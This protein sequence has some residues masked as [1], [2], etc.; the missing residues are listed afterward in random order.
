MV[1]VVEFATKIPQQQHHLKTTYLKEMPLKE[2]GHFAL[3]VRSMN[4]PYC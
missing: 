2:M 3:N 4:T 1:P